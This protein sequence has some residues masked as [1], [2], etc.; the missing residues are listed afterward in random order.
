MFDAAA[1]GPYVGDWKCETFVFRPYVK[2][3]SE[4]LS[5]D[6]I[7]ISSHANRLFMYDWIDSDKR[8]SV[9]E[10][11]SRDELLQNGFLHKS[12]SKTDHALF[13]KSYK[14]ELSKKCDCY[15]NYFPLNYSNF[16]QYPF[17]CRLYSKINVD[18]EITGDYFLFIP[19]DIECGKKIDDVY[20]VM[21]TMFSDDVIVVG[22][23]RA[24]L[25][26]HNVVL[27]KSDYFENG[28]EYILSY[29][30]NAKAV[31][32]PMGF[33]TFIADLQNKPVFS[34]VTEKH[35]NTAYR[36]LLTG[37]NCCVIQ[38]SDTNHIVN[39]FNNFV[40]SLKR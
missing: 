28:Y 21:R 18:K 29:I 36:G 23:M 10:D 37:R 40:K 5:I 11:I 7:F 34:W 35:G 27:A 6:K 32:C 31:I 8:L 24:H 4:T 30:N 22:D 38:T 14:E 33:W 25:I 12:V 15:I 2:W 19:D 9:Y 39:G 3:V 17:H 1:F 26:E 13:V 16:F 20:D